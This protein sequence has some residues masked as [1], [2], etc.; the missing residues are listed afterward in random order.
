VCKSRMRKH[1]SI[2][3]VDKENSFGYNDKYKL[4]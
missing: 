1:I 3:Q 4:I 2:F